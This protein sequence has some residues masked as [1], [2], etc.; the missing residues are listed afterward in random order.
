MPVALKGR[1]RQRNS[2]EDP[3]EF[4]ATLVEH[5]EELRDR[6]IRSVFIIAVFWAI[7]WII[8]PWLF[9]ALDARIKPAIL[10][11]VKPG[12]DVQLAVFHSA[13][14]AFFLKLKLSFFLGLGM[15]IPFVIYQ[16][17]SFVAPGLKPSERKPIKQTVPFSVALFVMGASFCWMVLPSAFGWFATYIEEFKG[18]VLFQEAGGLVFMSIKL[19]IAFG[20]G[21]QLPLIVFILGRIGLLSPDTLIRNWRQA[22]VAVFTISAII[23]P[24][25]DIPTMLMMAIPLCILFM[26]SV[27]AVKYTARK[28]LKYEAELNDLD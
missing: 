23:T 4:R 16:L 5:L 11:T 3:E 25:N 12:T 27:F 17:W 18:A 10:H 1:I 7:G 20:I 8:E 9:A 22:T 15:S 6:V 21:F 19:L 13:M 2:S 26:L 28:S 14:D 24:S